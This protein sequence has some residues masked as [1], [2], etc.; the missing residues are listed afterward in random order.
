MASTNDI[1]GG[2]STA[3]APKRSKG[4]AASTKP[5]G[6]G[7]RGG[8]DHRGARREGGGSR[9]DDRRDRGDGGGGGRGG[10][11]HSGSSKPAPPSVP[12]P[13]APIGGFIFFCNNETIDENLE[14]GIFGLVARWTDVVREIKP[15]LP[16]FLYNYSNKEMHGGFVAA[17]QGAF[18]IDPEAW[19]SA[20]FGNK[21]K[22]RRGKKVSLPAAVANVLPPP[23]R[24]SHPAAPHRSAALHPTHLRASTYVLQ[25]TPHPR[26][27]ALPPS[28]SF[29]RFCSTARR[30]SPRRCASIARTTTRRFR[31]PAFLPPR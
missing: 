8:S 22:Q 25:R 13:T 5:S 27:L 16:L 15:G 9:S 30:R 17:S 31:S 18:N 26:S 29:P 3:A 12:V 7:F 1:S 21:P 11:P 24:A 19:L 28:P 2:W 14:R 4:R 10:S 23:L 20:S 6:G